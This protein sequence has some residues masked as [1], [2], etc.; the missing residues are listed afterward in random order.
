M[1]SR[2]SLID[3]M[4]DTVNVQVNR[5]QFAAVRRLHAYR[6][7]L[8]CSASSTAMIACSGGPDSVALVGIAAVAFAAGRI[9]RPVVVHVD[10]RTRPETIDEAKLV[11]RIARAVEL[12]FVASAVSACTGMVQGGPEAELRDQRYE[13]L[14]R[15][16]WM[17]G[18]RTVLTAHTRDDQVETILLRMV[19][20]TG[21]RAIAGMQSRSTRVT[22][23][24]Q[25]TIRRPLLDVPKADLEDVRR[26]LRLPAADDPT[27][28][29]LS[30]RRNRVRHR[31]V[32]EL[33]RLDPGFGRGLV[34]AA[35]HASLD[36][37]YLDTLAATLSPSL[38]VETEDAISI[39]SKAIA[40]LDRAI[41]SRILR[42]TIAR[43]APVGTLRELTAERTWAV[44]DAVQKPP[45]TIIELPGNLR[46]TVNQTSLEISGFRTDDTQEERC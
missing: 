19:S 23:C 43:F 40:E 16:G 38:V 31:I 39:D 33:E 5:R 30:F 20:G 36:S 9:P 24:G 32:P 41:A 14:A 13:A 4:V 1:E 26:L 45:G 21:S 7:F 44:L 29:D 34:R 27:N 3:S 2:P 28:D 12:P 37:R 17:L 11:R 35:M 22:G 15:T 8:E 46:V 18:I 25:L 10:H 42:A 6:D